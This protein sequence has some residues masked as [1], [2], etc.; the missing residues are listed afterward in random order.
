[1]MTYAEERPSAAE[2][3]DLFRAAG[4]NGPLDDLPRIQRMI[5]EAQQVLTARLDGRLVGLIRVLTDFAYNAFI[6]DLAVHP[7][8]QRRR[9]GSTLVSRAT[10]RWTGVKFVV[11]AGHDSGG[12][13]LRHGFVPAP[14][15][16]VR[17]RQP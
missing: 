10:D 17:G 7:D 15:C 4:L 9:V 8:V 3:V 13:W 12:F 5:E 2:V 16:L 14:S 11:H 6:T 1:M